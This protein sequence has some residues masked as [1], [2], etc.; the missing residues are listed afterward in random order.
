MSLGWVPEI[1]WPVVRAQL[2]RAV[3]TEVGEVRHCNTMRQFVRRI[4]EALESPSWPL[5]RN[6]VSDWARAQHPDIAARGLAGADD[7][8]VAWVVAQDLR[9]MLVHLTVKGFNEARSVVEFI[10][11]WVCGRVSRSDAERLGRRIA[12]E[13]ERQIATNDRDGRLSGNLVYAALHLALIPTSWSWCTT[14]A[15]RAVEHIVASS[16]GNYRDARHTDVIADAVHTMP[17][18]VAR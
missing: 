18:E 6:A 7:K 9:A 17:W 15:S 10:E 13:L 16:L 14:H 8:L 2:P 12:D 11:G 3:V 1:V 4:D 5:W